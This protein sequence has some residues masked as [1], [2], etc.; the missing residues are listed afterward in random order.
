MKNKIIAHDLEHL[1]DLIQE[2]IIRS[3]FQC[4]LNHIDV[5]QITS[6]ACL[7]TN[8]QFNGNISQWD[9]SKV[10]SMN[11]MFMNAKFNGDISGWD[12]SNIESMRSMFTRSKFNGDISK[13]NVERVSSFYFMFTGSDFDGDISNWNVENVEY[14]SCMFTKSK[15]TG[16]LTEWKPY[17]AKISSIFENCLAPS[18]YWTNYEDIQEREKVI[19]QYTN[20]KKL[21]DKLDKDLLVSTETTNS[22]PKAKM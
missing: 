15:F 20:A 18:P 17:K 16:N 14:M 4:D 21:H 3:G 9:V 19:K 7:F 13:W 5:S 11:N 8:S 10:T 1:K 6:M 22:N 2:E 12:V